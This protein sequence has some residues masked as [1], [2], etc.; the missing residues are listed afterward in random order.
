MKQVTLNAKDVLGQD[1]TLVDSFENVKKASKGL[2]K[3]FGAM[4]E[5]EDKAKAEN[6]DLL[7]PEYGMVINEYVVKNVA[8]LL[9]LSATD[10]KS[11]EKMS[12][13]DVTKFYEKVA[14][15]FCQMKVPTM[16]DATGVGE[17]DE[18]VESNDKGL[19]TVDPK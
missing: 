11:L 17:D 19:K 1:F 6:R 3:M 5:L 16:G 15:E 12:R 14:E 13:S 9:H 7:L 18:S 8:D 10:T 2:L 4:N